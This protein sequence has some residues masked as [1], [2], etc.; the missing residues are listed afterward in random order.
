[1][2]YP[3]FDVDEVI[4]GLEFILGTRDL[5]PYHRRM[6]SSA[7][8]QLRE[9][10]FDVE[11]HYDLIGRDR[12]DDMLRTALEEARTYGNGPFFAYQGVEGATTQIELYGQLIRK[13]FE[14]LQMNPYE[15]TE[16]LGLSLLEASLMAANSPTVMVEQEEFSLEDGS[17]QLFDIP[18]VVDYL[19][20]LVHVQGVVDDSTIIGSVENP[21][22]VHETL[23]KA[24]GLPEE[25]YLFNKYRLAIQFERNR[26]EYFS[27]KRIKYE[28]DISES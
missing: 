28:P 18:L 12:V 2:V 26:Q 3:E 5:I 16:D 6:F 15:L 20:D 24:V 27:A 11:A 10:D 17:T 1:M 21:I 19:T 4:D 23:F 25:R 9:E 7:A 13:A 14:V 8:H 22:P